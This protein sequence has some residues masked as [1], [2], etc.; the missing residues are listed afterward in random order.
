MDASALDFDLPDELIAQ[1]PAEP[2]DN[3]RLLVCSRSDPGFVEHRVF[4]ELPMFLDGGDRLV[5]NTTAVVPAR[6][7]GVRADSGGKV[8][9]LYLNDV[10]GDG[11]RWRVLLKSNGKLRAGA[12]VELGGGKAIELLDRDE[13]AWIVG[14]E[15][16]GAASE[17]GTMGVLAAV[18]ATPLPPYILKARSDAGEAIADDEDRA[19]YQTVYADMAARGSVAAPSR[20]W[21]CSRAWAWTGP[22]CCCTSAR[23]RSDRSPRATWRG[24]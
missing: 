7:G 17:G 11:L 22:T 16:R 9:G 5:F 1:R 3:A 8:E 21:T 2:R 4:R 19:W 13:E 23:A 12:R 10:E 18:G 14:V 6:L 15:G 20:A 24:T